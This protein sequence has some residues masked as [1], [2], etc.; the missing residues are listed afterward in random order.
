M[1]P[2][3]WILKCYAETELQSWSVFLLYSIYCCHYT[4]VIHD[5]VIIFI[6]IVIVIVID[7]KYKRGPFSDM[8]LMIW[9]MLKDFQCSG[10]GN[11]CFI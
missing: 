7:V 11:N 8:I 3:S 2:L 1:L 4:Y 5:N 9:C 6:V 10:T